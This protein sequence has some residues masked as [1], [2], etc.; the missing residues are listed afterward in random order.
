[1]TNPDASLAKGCRTSD[2]RAVTL[3]SDADGLH[4][5]TADSSAAYAWKSVT[6]LAE[7]GMNADLWV[8]N[9]CL[10]DR[11]H[12]VV[13]YAP[14]AFTNKEE[15]MERGAFTA[16]VDLD[17]GAA[18][19]LPV[20]ASLAYFD[21]SCDT[22]THTAVVTQIK[23]DQTKLV[24]ISAQGR[25]TA[26]A[27]VQGEV[28][29]ATPTAGGLVGALDHRVVRIAASGATT[30]L[31]TTDYVPYGMHPDADGVVVFLDQTAKSQHAKRIH[32]GKVGVLATGGLSSLGLTEGAGGQVFLSGRPTSTAALPAHVRKVTAQASADVSTRGALAVTSAATAAVDAQLADPGSPPAADA[33]G[34]VRVQAQVTATGHA[35]TFDAAAGAT[36]DQAAAQGN[37]VSPSLA[38]PQ[39]ATAKAAAGS[40]SPNVVTSPSGD[41]TAPDRY[42]SITRNDPHQQALQPTP[43]QVE[44]AVDMAIRGDLTSTWVTQGGRRTTEGIGT[45]NPQGTVALPPLTGGGRIPAAVL[46]GVLARE[47]N[48]WQAEG[49]VI[50][51]QTGNP[52]ASTNGYYGHPAGSD[53]GLGYWVI[54][55]EN[56]DCGYGVGQITDGMR[57]ASHPKGSVPA[58]PAAQQKDI[59]LD[60]TFNIAKAAQM[61][62]G[63]W[64]EL[65]AAGQK[66]TIND[67]SASKIENWFAAVWNYNEGYN[68]PGSDASG[69]WGLGWY[70]NPA[71]PIYK[72]T[73]LAFLDTTLDAAAN[74]DAAHPQDWP[75]QE[76]VLG[77][78]AWSID[79]TRSYSSDGTQDAPGAA[80]FSSA[81]FSPAWWPGGSPGT[82]D[83]NRQNVKPPLATF[84]TQAGNACSVSSPPT[85]ETNGQHDAT[86]DP[87]HWWHRANTTWKPDCVNT[88]GQETLKYAT[89]R[90]ELLE[91]VHQLAPNARIALLGYPLLFDTSAV[92]CAD[93]AGDTDQIAAWGAYMNSDLQTAVAQS[94]TAGKAVFWAPTAEFSGHLLCDGSPG[95]HGFTKTPSS[96]VAS[97]PQWSVTAPSSIESYHPNDNGAGYYA[98]ALMHVLGNIS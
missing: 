83:L 4:V 53:L 94:N 77:F 57:L 19:K 48:L 15:L 51:G 12:A 26:V 89:L 8:G 11:S 36:G 20:T 61:L 21:P 78:A 80:G 69:N 79:T 41:T 5:M 37:A 45:A 88:C 29:S 27:T 34:R 95:L 67:D 87:P 74:S 33:A 70:G 22:V 85:C 97:D 96:D 38:A 91:R 7:P 28:T 82:G 71:N 6:T 92:E 98:A 62:A 3:A 42:C 10:T 56:S 2:D 65:H 68:T 84:C 93:P 40:A 58:L 90:T 59:A 66:M 30:T 25:P 1:M 9:Y 32:G 63:K 16:V 23:D 47:S 64:N 73:R 39:S 46:L 52:L 76:R 43:N 24:S 55:W 14:R 35:V 44:W 17:T 31:A 75:Y 13:V 49:G 86:C 50:P 18:T 81:G 54:N 60:Y 72:S